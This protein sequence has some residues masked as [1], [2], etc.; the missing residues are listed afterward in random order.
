MSGVVVTGV[1]VVSALGEGREAFASGLRAG[2]SPVSRLEGDAWAGSRSR[3]AARVE[4]FDPSAWLPAKWEGR[5]GR[6]AAFAIACARM[7]VRDAG[8]FD[9]EISGEDTGLALACAIGGAAEADE[10]PNALLLARAAPSTA[11]AWISQAFGIL[12]PGM[13]VGSASCGG[14]QALSVAAQMIASGRA[15][16]VLAGGVETPLT[17]RVFAA[18]DAA[19]VLSRRNDEPERAL[20]PFDRQRA[21]T[22]A[23]EGGAV[24]MLENAED[25]ERRGARVLARLAGTG[26]AMEA[27]HPYSLSPDGRAAR[28]ALGRA[29]REARADGADVE[30]VVTHGTG[31]RQNDEY[32]AGVI[33]AILGTRV[34]VTATK[35]MTGHLLGAAGAMDAAAAVTAMAAGFAP[36]IVN[37]DDPEPG[38]RLD[39]VRGEART[40]RPDLVALMS[41]GLGGFSSALIFRRA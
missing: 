18:L 32:E 39:L 34:M 36:P 27:H 33:E 12:G 30:M 19:G 7:A 17:P 21:G 5:V 41:H 3:V 35:P 40:A 14:A 6:H 2:R 38:A 24:L 15:R 25:A 4:G 23:G 16:R 20:R 9:E 29:L 11:V 10:A 26:D 28:A 13:L 8:L 31:T 22:V 37:C 1:G